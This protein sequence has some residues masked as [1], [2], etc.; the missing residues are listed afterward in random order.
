MLIAQYGLDIV[1]GTIRAKYPH[2]VLE[3]CEDGG[4]MIDL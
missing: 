3:N 1:I 2:V 4:M